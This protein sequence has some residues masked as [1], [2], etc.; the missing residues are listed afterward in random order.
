MLPG[1][2]DELPKAGPL[3]ELPNDPYTNH[4]RFRYVVERPTLLY[5]V[6]PDRK[7]DHASHDVDARTGDGDVIF[8][9]RTDQEK[10]P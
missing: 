9:L 8:P 6:G 1:S 4:E 5:S 10:R 3:R 7:D 2:L